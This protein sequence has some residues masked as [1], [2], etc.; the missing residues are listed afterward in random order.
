MFAVYVVYLCR[1]INFIYDHNNQIT[2]SSREWYMSMF[3]SAGIC[4]F[5]DGRPKNSFKN[6]IFIFT[7]TFV[8]EAIM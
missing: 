3:T 8:I 4:G 5:C 7:G 6:M 2:E 1:S